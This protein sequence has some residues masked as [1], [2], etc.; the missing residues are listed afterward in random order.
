MN[1]KGNSILYSLNNVE[2]YKISLHCPTREI[3]NKLNILIVDYLKFINEKV[4]LKNPSCNKFILIRGMETICHVFN[5]ILYYSKNIDLAF[6][7]AQKAFYFYVEFIEQITDDQ[8]TFLQLN[9]RDAS[10]FVYK[11]T[12]FD[13]NDE[14]CKNMDKNIDDNTREQFDVLYI[15]CQIVRSVVEFFVHNNYISINEEK[16]KDNKKIKMTIIIEKIS[17]L[18]NKLNTYKFNKEAYNIILLFV[19]QLN[20]DIHYDKYYEVVELFLKKIQKGKSIEVKNYE[21]MVNP[22][23]YEKLEDNPSKFIN[24]LFL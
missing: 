5:Q 16:E 2:N 11:K 4:N 18:I 21:K 17:N 19:K 12:I 7:H 6:Y 13:I 24:W 15:H 20:I 1:S 8:H 23:F 22:A 3:L 10:L 9:S 14:Y